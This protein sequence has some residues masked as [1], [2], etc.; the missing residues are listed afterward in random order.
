MGVLCLSLM[1]GHKV[2]QES[3]WRLASAVILVETGLWVGSESSM[4]A[5]TRL[6]SLED[7]Y[8]MPLA[9]G[10]QVLLCPT[11]TGLRKTTFC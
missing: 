10:Q 1:L 2:G 8:D 11:F 6:R 4:A 9:G 7:L 5:N 3:G